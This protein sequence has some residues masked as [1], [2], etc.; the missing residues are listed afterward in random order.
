V[1]K[2]REQHWIIGT[3]ASNGTFYMKDC[4]GEDVTRDPKEAYGFYYKANAEEH[5]KEYFRRPHS[6]VKRR[7][8]CK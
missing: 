7:G 2:K 3:D 4:R 5:Q 6:F 1:E 8:A